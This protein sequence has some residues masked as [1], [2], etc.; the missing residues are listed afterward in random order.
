MSDFTV[1]NALSTVASMAD[2]VGFLTDA[3][4]G[5][6]HDTREALATLSADLH[7]WG[8]ETRNWRAD[9]S[10]LWDAEQEALQEFAHRLAELTNRVF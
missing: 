7:A 5:S 9:G 2:V 6:S 3:A 4:S 10:E 1:R 8:D